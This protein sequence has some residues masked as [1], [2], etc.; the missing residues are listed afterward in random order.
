MIMIFSSDWKLTK[1]TLMIMFDWVNDTWTQLIKLDYKNK[2]KI[3]WFSKVQVTFKYIL[4]LK[5]CNK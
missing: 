4:Y 2:P 3:N 5:W 1:K